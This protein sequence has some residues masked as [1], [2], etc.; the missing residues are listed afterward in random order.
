MNTNIYQ[1]IAFLFYHFTA[2]FV[3]ITGVCLIFHRDIKRYVSFLKG[4]KDGLKIEPLSN[5]I[6]DDNKK[7]QLLVY[8]E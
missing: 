2:D 6:L 7:Y 4:I 1:R 5:N 8:S 3:F